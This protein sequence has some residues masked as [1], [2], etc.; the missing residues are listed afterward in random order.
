[1]DQELEHSSAES[2]ALGCSQTAMQVLARAGVC[3]KLEWGRIHFQDH[4]VVGGIQFLKGC[5]TA[6]FSSSP[7]AG[8]KAL[9]KVF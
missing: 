4:T 1:M 6:D 8:Q 3:G 9:S 5:G 2:S 7:A